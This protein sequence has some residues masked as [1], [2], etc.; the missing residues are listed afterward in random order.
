MSFGQTFQTG[1]M[2][3][4]SSRDEELFLSVTPEFVFGP[5][6]RRDGLTPPQMVDPHSLTSITGTVPD[7]PERLPPTTG[8][9]A[10]RA[11]TWTVF[12]HA[13]RFL[14]EHGKDYLIIGLQGCGDLTMNP[15]HVALVRIQGK[16]ILCH[17]TY[18]TDHTLQEP[19]DERI[20][21]CLVKWKPGVRGEKACHEFIDLRFH[22][23]KPQ[24]EYAAEIVDD[25]FKRKHDHLFH[26]IGARVADRIEFA[27]AGKPIVQKGNEIPLANVIDRF[28]DVR[29]VF[30]VP[31]VPAS[32]Q[33]RG[34]RI[35]S[36]NLGEY[37]LY[38]NLN[39]RRAALNSPIIVDLHV[40]SAVRCDWKHVSDELEKKR[41]YKLDS[42]SPSRRGRYR[43]YAP[44]LIEVFYPH[45]VYPF[46]V[47]GGKA[48]ELVCLSSGGLSGR[49][50]NT[51]EGITRIMYD[52]FGCEDSMVMDEGYDTFLLLNPNQ[53]EKE[54]DEDRYLHNND[55]MLK[56]VAAF[57]RWR[58]DC[59]HADS[60]KEGHPLGRGMKDW[61]LNQKLLKEL[62]D[63]CMAADIKGKSPDEVDIVSVAP[64][65][66]QLRAVFIL[67]KRIT[68]ESPK[69]N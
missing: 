15:W 47:I 66:S 29:H 10:Q 6:I 54:S 20:Y 48:D 40:E 69:R 49:V 19:Y 12:N 24:T 58:V 42:E 34:A 46:G 7:N 16:P 14:Q 25:S 23:I 21:R 1:Y 8:A 17:L 50:G 44:N 41:H 37:I 5:G 35:T 9:F 13:L 56:A 45:N 55:D 22:R 28:Q 67:A 18:S 62:D 68:N 52:F 3:I 31:E 4:S 36:I 2:K 53:K 11:G 57:S 32:G 38:N 63:Y 64:N 30:N 33:F 61:P 60:V 51:L 26:E 65:R 27:V 39:S 43:A 59:D